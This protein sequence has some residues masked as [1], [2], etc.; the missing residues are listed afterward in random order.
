MKLK[1]NLIGLLTVNL[2]LMILVLTC[3]LFKDFNVLYESLLTRPPAK[4][5]TDD[6]RWI[7]MSHNL[8]DL[9]AVVA[10][11]GF[12]TALIGIF[13]S[14]HNRIYAILTVVFVII[15][16]VLILIMEKPVHHQ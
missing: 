4:W 8:M 10:W 2:A 15:S 16:W 6:P 12:L 13:H 1:N 3:I 11:S 5:L 9:G 7:G 14:Q